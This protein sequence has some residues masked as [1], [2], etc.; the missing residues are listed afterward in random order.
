MPAPQPAPANVKAPLAASAIS[1]HLDTRTAATEIADILFEELAGTGSGCDLA[2]IFGS[3]HH[4]AA[5]DEAAALIRKTVDA[6]TVLGVT[7][8]AALGEDRERDGYA[9]LS[10]IAMRFPRGC[11]V[12]VHAWHSTPEDPAA[13]NDPAR[14]RERIGLNDAEAG[15]LVPRAV[16]MFG[17]PFSTPVTRLLP[18]LNV[19]RGDLPA[20]PVIGGM[21]SGASQPG[22]NV[23]VINDRTLQAGVIG[24]TIS[25]DLDIDFIVSQGCRPVGKPMVIT[26]CNQNVVQEL[27]GRKA[28]DALREMAEELSES[29]KRLLGRGLLMGTV[30]NEYKEYFGRGDFLVRN[31]M[32]LDEKAGTIAVGEMCRPGQTVQF[33]VRDAAT[34][35]E[36]LQLLLDAQVLNPVQPFAALLFTCNGRGQRLFGQPNH[37]IGIIR[38]RIGEVPIAGFFAAGEFGP[39]GDRSFL[40]GHTASLA[41]LRVRPAAPA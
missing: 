21:A 34:A 10:A 36:D 16:V 24:A 11:N 25:G 5:F 28:M 4:R 17:D 15:G 19:C 14:L 20:V 38:E 13:L 33:H 40:H 1:G 23:M 39:I 32:S 8:E 26:R 31:V 2:L 30:I 27:G 12:R 37:D 6:R 18:A 41:L 3:Y 22:A 35:A 29:E 7:C 9:G